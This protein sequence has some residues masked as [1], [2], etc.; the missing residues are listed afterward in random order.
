[1]EIMGS[2]RTNS[3][4]LYRRVTFGMVNGRA[5]VIGVEVWSVDPATLPKRATGMTKKEVVRH[6]H[7][8]VWMPSGQ[9]T[10]AIRSK[11]LRLPL[12]QMV[13][14]FIAGRRRSATLITSERFLQETA[15]D[16]P[17]R[18][19]PVQAGARQFLALA[20]DEAP[21]RVG[22]PALPASHYAEVAAVYTDALAH[23][24]DPTQAVINTFRCRNRLPPSGSTDA[25]GHH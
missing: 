24:D 16:D 13:T 2:E 21:A 10:G 8:P 6:W 7:W 1:V 23:R 14:K 11:D 25:A 20:E 19:R 9:P 5:E 18:S 15:P 12:G 17:R 22:R 3:G 4:A